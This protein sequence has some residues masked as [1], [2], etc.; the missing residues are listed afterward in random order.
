MEAKLEPN[1]A[2]AVDADEAVYEDPIALKRVEDM[3]EPVL[4][5]GAGHIYDRV[6]IEEWIEQKGT[7]PVFYTP[8][9]VQML[10][11]GRF[12]KPLATDAKTQRDAHFMGILAKMQ[13]TIERNKAEAEQARQESDAKAEKEREKAAQERQENAA[14]FAKYE[15]VIQSLKEEN[16]DLKAKLRTVTEE[17]TRLKAGYVNPA[18]AKLGGAVEDKL[19]KGST[20]ERHAVL[21]AYAKSVK[22]STDDERLRESV[23][24]VELFLR[25]EVRKPRLCGGWFSWFGSVSETTQVATEL[26]DK[27]NMEKGF[28]S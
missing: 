18:Y 1:R 12:V 28:T 7:D 16:S 5:P 11:P 23:N 9:T 15:N 20:Y 24:D 3:A 21:E 19:K 17:N 8:L 2:A 22:S 27:I 25:P 6:D 10:V 4:T 14:R 26:R 13:E